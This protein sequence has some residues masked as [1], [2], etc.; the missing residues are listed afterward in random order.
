MRMHIDPAGGD[1]KAVSVVFARAGPG[2]A[3]DRGDLAAVDRD[4]AREGVAA[5][6]V[7]NAAAANDDIVHA[8]PP[9]IARC[10]MGLCPGRRNRPS[11]HGPMHLPCHCEERSDEAISCG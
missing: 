9:E 5:G 10:S 6:A 4:A 11:L 2:L 1:E 8:V 3:A 7:E